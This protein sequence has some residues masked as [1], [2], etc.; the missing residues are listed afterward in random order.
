MTRL[1]TKGEHSVHLVFLVR[2]VEALLEASRDQFTM[3]VVQRLARRAE[4]CVSPELSGTAWVQVP[5][6]RLFQVQ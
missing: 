4:Q 5:I 3:P 6:V 2:A 1:V